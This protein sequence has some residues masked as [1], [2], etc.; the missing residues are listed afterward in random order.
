MD[1]SLRLL[2]GSVVS[3]ALA[4]A[5]VPA[6]HGEDPTAACVV[7]YI[8]AAPSLATEARARLTTL[9]DPA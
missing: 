2:L 6:P 3:A 7:A 5:L 8:E 9:R 4:A 1:A